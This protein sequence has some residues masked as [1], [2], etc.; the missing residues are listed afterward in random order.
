[1][2]QPK[3]AMVAAL[4]I[5]LAMAG[6]VGWVLIAPDDEGAAGEDATPY[7][8]VNVERRD[9]RVGIRVSGRWGY[10]AQQPIPIRRSGTVTW[11]PPVGEQASLGDV[12]V[13]VDDR[14][15]VLM[16]GATPAYRTMDTGSRP[17]PSPSGPPGADPDNGEKNPTPPTVPEEPV[18]ASVGP[19]V[20][21]LELGLSRLGYS[22]FTVDEEFTDATA[23]AVRAWQEDLGAPATGRVEFG[24]VVFLPGPIRLHPSPG[25]LGQGVSDSS[26]QQSGTQ[27]LVTAEVDDADWAQAGV[28]V[29]VTLPNQKTTTG[30]VV[31]VGSVGGDSEGG[32]GSSGMAAQR[33]TIRLTRDYP[34][35][36]PGPVEVT[37]VSA[38]AD[39]VLTV[40]VTALVALAEGGYGVQVADGGYVAVEPGLY[41]E[42]LVE[43]GGDLEV[44]TK[45]RVP[46]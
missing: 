40:P 14:P 43:V 17:D 24:D 5:L 10:G 22:G 6:V 13:R 28:R 20:E 46:K 2:I 1:M 7:D 42:G 16:Y 31:A 30:K 29:E 15:V 9:L 3:R 41:A 25:S 11:L 27:R 45:I 39:D 32:G 19:D 38:R 21:Q 37:Y 36:G 8:L 33:V 44:G 26:V 35:I 34:R 18:P 12:L 4:V 23:A